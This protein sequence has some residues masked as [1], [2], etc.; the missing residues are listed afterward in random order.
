MC[1]Q[2]SRA[3]S[4]PSEDAM[5]PL[6]LPSVTTFLYFLLSRLCCCHSRVVFYPNSSSRG[7]GQDSIHPFLF[8]SARVLIA[9]TNF[10][11]YTGH[12]STDTTR[13]TICGNCGIS[14]FRGYLLLEENL[15]CRTSLRETSFEMKYTFLL[16]I[17]IKHHTMKTCKGV[18][19]Y[20][21]A[22]SI[23]VLDR[24][25]CLASRSVR[26]TA[27]KKEPPFEDTV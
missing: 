27:Q 15:D 8:S 10:R 20:L 24:D 11:S 7:E 13:W 2:F 22:F 1:L 25:D 9:I 21:D 26:F 12:T 3:P 6:A 18:T 17:L 23:P 5:E 19:L 16:Q 14:S 4:N